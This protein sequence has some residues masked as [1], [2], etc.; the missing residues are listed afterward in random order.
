LSPGL[1]H[2]QQAQDHRARE[3]HIGPSPTRLAGGQLQP[4]AQ[5]HRVQD[6]HIDRSTA[7]QD[8]RRAEPAALIRP[9]RSRP[10]GLL[11][12]AHRPASSHLILSLRP[13]GSSHPV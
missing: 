7:R 11:K 9:D 13:G 6:K 4:E 1:Q 5:D 2:Q 10:P 8:D 3:R 12:N